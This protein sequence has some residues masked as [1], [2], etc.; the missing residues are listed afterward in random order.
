[1]KQK[2]NARQKRD[3][4]ALRRKEAFSSGKKKISENKLK[5]ESRQKPDIKIKKET[6]P[7]PI[8]AESSPAVSSEEETR[9]FLEYLEQYG[10]PE[11][12]TDSVKTGGRKANATEIIPGLNLEDGMPIVADAL[13]HM[14]M[15]LQEMR[16]SRVKAVKLIHGYGSSGRGG[17]IRIGVRNELAAMKNRKQI[18][19]YIPGEDFG[20]T[21]QASRNLVERNR[22]VTHDPDYGKMNH[23]ITIVILF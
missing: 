17:K 8:P 19:D 15:G 16:Y 9:E 22:N 18:K 3:A 1:M 7:K 6:S 11:S 14:R 12:A 21:D 23:G 4:E 10:V 5:P 13:N 2:A 20:P